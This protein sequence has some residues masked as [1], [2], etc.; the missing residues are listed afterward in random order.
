MKNK[1]VPLKKTKTVI[2]KRNDLFRKDI[3]NDEA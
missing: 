2:A 3:E 1:V